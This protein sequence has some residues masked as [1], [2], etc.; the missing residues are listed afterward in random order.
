VAVDVVSALSNLAVNRPLFHS[1][2]DLQ[3]ALAWQVHQMHPTARVRLET[4]PLRG[5]RLDLLLV[6]DGVRI[7][8]ELKYLV[9]KFSGLVDGEV[10]ELPNQSAQDISRHDVVKDI[11]R[12]ETMVRDGYADAGYALTLTNDASYWRQ[13]HK[14]NPID[15]AF[16]LDEGR[17]LSGTLGWASLAGKGTT[18]KRDA[19]LVLEGS[20]ECRWA[21]YSMVNGSDGRRAEFR[22]LCLE[23]G[24]SLRGGRQVFAVQASPAPPALPEGGRVALGVRAEILEAARLIAVAASDGTFTVAEIVDELSRRG[25]RYSESTVRT[26]VVSRMCLNAPDHHAT[27]FSDFVRTGPGRYRLYVS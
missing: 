22:Y 15:A 21:P 7:A 24:T 5:I 10:Y 20:Y 2:A 6:A 17:S 9:A 16:R 8:V 11:V 3:H 1:E 12:L 19:P 13:G 14:A 26:H 27:V 4:R 25:S 18:H 23:V